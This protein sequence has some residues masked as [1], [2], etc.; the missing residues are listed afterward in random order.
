VNWS[1]PVIVKVPSIEMQVAIDAS[2]RA[3]HVIMAHYDR[4]IRA[5]LKPDGTPVTQADLEAEKIIMDLIRECFPEHAFLSEE[6]GER[7]SRSELVWVIDPIDGTKN[8]V[9]GIPFFATQIA[10]LR[11]GRPVLGVSNAPALQELLYAEVGHGAYLNGERVQVSNVDDLA[12]AYISLGGLNHFITSGQLEEVLRVVGEAG[13]V[14]GFGDAYAYHLVATGRFEAVVETGIHIWDVAAM[15][16]IIDEAG[17]RCTDDQGA[18]ISFDTTCVICSNGK[19][20]QRLLALLKQPQWGELSKV[21][22]A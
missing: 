16:V 8:Y 1:K 7:G 2:R 22:Q 11:N 6:A 20:H 15:S 14:R 13:R 12:Q 4:S 21:K 9:R 18:N 19:I 5:H 10:L 3:Q 17:G